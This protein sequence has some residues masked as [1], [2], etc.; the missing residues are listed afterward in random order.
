MAK[1]VGFSTEST[2]Q[3]SVAGIGTLTVEVNKKPPAMVVVGYRSPPY[4][5]SNGPSPTLPPLTESD[6]AINAAYHDRAI[7]AAPTPNQPAAT[8]EPKVPLGFERL[9]AWIATPDR[10]E[11]ILHTL[12]ENFQ[13]RIQ[14]D[15][16][17]AARNWYRWQ[18]IRTFGNSLLQLAPRLAGLIYVLRKIGFF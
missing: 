12:D 4:P 7:N 11:F 13:K 16:E 2:L 8:A 15:G 5:R 3:A 14:R 1:E 10:L 18:V 6:R 9:L 17:W